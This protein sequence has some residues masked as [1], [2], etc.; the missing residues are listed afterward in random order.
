MLIRPLM[1]RRPDLAYHK[2]HLFFQP[3]GHFWRAIACGHNRRRYR[4]KS[5]V[6]PLFAGASHFLLWGE[7]PLGDEEGELRLS[8]SWSDPGRA[9][10]ELCDL[11]ERQLLPRIA[12]V[13]TPEELAKYPRYKNAVLDSIFGACFNGDF[14]QAE[15][16]AVDYV[17]WYS[18]PITL[19]DRTTD[20]FVQQPYSVEDVT[21][22]HRFNEHMEWRVAY[23]AKLL[24]TGRSRVPALLHD[25]EEFTVNAFKLNEY[26]TRTPFPFE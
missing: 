21:E 9:S 23:L 17:R 16:C 24:Q 15:R 7:M 8:A 19:L 3:V 14:D 13:V 18:S 10:M 20:K 12:S 25:W 26:W 5:F 1:E 4:F 11:L 2:E 22:D 6:Y